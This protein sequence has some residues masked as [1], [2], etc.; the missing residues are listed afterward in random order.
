MEMAHTERPGGEALQDSSFMSSLPTT[1]VGTMLRHTAATDREGQ[2]AVHWKEFGVEILHL[3]C[4]QGENKRKLSLSFGA[5]VE[6]PD[7]RLQA[8]IT[9]SSA[10][11]T[12]P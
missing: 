10:M 4:T 2:Q 3:Q 8:R 9:I 12:T 1:I 5:Q 11:W 6:F 7:Q